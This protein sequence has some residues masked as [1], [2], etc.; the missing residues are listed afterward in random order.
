MQ[1]AKH[2]KIMHYKVNVTLQPS[3]PGRSDTYHIPEVVRRPCT[4]VRRI[5]SVFELDD[6]VV[7]DEVQIFPHASISRPKILQSTPGATHA[8]DQSQR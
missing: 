7:K 2:D 3:I 4:R 1:Q 6:V 5:V 8:A